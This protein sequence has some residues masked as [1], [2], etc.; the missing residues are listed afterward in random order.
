[1]AAQ[2]PH[3]H[4]GKRYPAFHQRSTGLYQTLVSTLGEYRGI[5]ACP[6]RYC[7][8]SDG[9]NFGLNIHGTGGTAISVW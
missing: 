6:L 4:Q 7:L 5:L 8:Q 2:I 3:L 1:M 9:D